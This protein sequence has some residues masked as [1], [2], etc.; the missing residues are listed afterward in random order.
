MTGEPRVATPKFRILSIDGGGIRGV[1]PAHIVHRIKETFGINPK[2]HFQMLAGTST[3]SIIAAGLAC[4]VA[5]EKIVSLYRAKGREI[6][7]PK[8]SSWLGFLAPVFHSRYNNA[9]LASALKEIF[10]DTKLGDISIPL[11]L[12][13]T[14][15]G[16]GGVHVF[17]SAYS[18]GF[19]RDNRVLVRDAVLASCS[20]PTYFDPYR[21]NEYALVDGGVWANNPSLAAVIDAQK[22]LGIELAD[23]SVLSLG[24]GMS[25]S[26]F[27]ANLSRKWNPFRSIPLLK[28][29]PGFIKWRWGFATGWR[30]SGFIEFLMSVQAQSIDNYL[31]LLLKKEQL[32]RINF[33]SDLPLPLDDCSAI[34]DL[35]SRADHEFTHGSEH[36]REFLN[37]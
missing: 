27:S 22:R 6:F 2:D 17:K 18:K 4:G 21:V 15:I 35:V 11:I 36:L 37:S 34:D 25:R 12:P 32:L 33:K 3:G 28:R 7:C 1:V 8:W 29:I 19:T 26:Y 20:A 23:I 14:D 24:T 9:G 10:G 13:A 16:N 30:T 31:Q 5:P